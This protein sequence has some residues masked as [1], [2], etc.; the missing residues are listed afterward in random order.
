MGNVIADPRLVAAMI[1][2]L[3]FHA[4]IIETG[5]NSYRLRSTRTAKRRKP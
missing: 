4:H 2:R 3:T 1:D 5:T